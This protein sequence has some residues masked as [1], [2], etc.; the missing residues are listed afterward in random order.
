MSEILQE[1]LFVNLNNLI[2]QYHPR[3]ALPANGGVMNQL[4]L[5]L[6]HCFM[7]ILR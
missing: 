6:K 7:C 1:V 5:R 4:Y 2:G 3:N